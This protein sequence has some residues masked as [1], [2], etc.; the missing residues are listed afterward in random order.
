MDQPYYSNG[1]MFSCTHCSACCRHD[2]GFVYLSEK[3]LEKLLKWFTLE[4]DVFISVFCHW[5]SC[6]DGFEYLSLKEKHNYDCILW[7]D[8]CTVY[9]NRPLQCSIYPFW[10]SLVQTKDSWNA[11]AVDCPGMNQGVLHDSYQIQTHLQR[12][13]E[14]PYITRPQR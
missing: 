3:D 6:G 12:R 11:A 1:L 14:Q 9:E 10:A 2:P 4:R 7:D 8:G 5:V 13:C